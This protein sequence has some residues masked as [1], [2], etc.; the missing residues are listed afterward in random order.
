MSTR[1]TD[2]R[3]DAEVARIKRMAIQR[4]ARVNRMLGALFVAAAIVAG[5]V[6]FLQP[7][8][9]R[10][11]GLSLGLGFATF[12]LGCI[13][14]RFLLPIPR[15]ECPQCGCDWRVES[16]NDLQKWLAWRCCPACGLKM[17]DDAGLN[18]KP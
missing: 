12:C 15:A 11:L 7:P 1:E 13:L 6:W 4:S 2:S 17:T 3:F 10:D 9:D 18:E 16:E 8:V 5:S 14:G